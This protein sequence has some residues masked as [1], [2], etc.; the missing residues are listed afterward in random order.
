MR[1]SLEP[2]LLCGDDEPVAVV[3]VLAVIVAWRYTV[4]GKGVPAARLAALLCAVIVVWF[5]VG[6][7]DPAAAGSVASGFLTGIS[8]AA[9]GFAAFLSH[10]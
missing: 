2:I 10:F 7:K 4:K 6:F 9:S 3:A 1:S 5:L 8:E